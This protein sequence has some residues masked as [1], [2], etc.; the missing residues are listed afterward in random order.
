M[1]KEYLKL[2]LNNFPVEEKVMF[3]VIGFGVNLG[4]GK[5]NTDP[6]C[7]W[8]QGG[9]LRRW[10]HPVPPTHYSLLPEYVVLSSE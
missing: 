5:Y 8:H 1:C 7:V 2:D 3:V 9:K 4:S 10:P 6:Y